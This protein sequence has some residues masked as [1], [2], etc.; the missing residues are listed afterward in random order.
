[1]RGRVPPGATH[2]QLFPDNAKALPHTPGLPRFTARSHSTAQQTKTSH[3]WHSEATLFT[4]G[5]K[6][7]G[8]GINQLLVMSESST[9]PKWSFMIQ[10]NDSN[11]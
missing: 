10:S 3:S 9:T 5:T 1:M 7:P 8:P 11:L 4:F 2:T 6:T